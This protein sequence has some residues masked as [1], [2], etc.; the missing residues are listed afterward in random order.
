MEII[1][2]PSPNHNERPAGDAVSC[3]V[4]HYT[5]MQSG[6]AALQR[7]VDPA[8][9]V[10]AH[11]LIEEDGLIYRLVDEERRAWHAGRSLWGGRDDINSVSVGIELVNPGHQWGYRAFPPAQMQSFIRLAREIIGRHRILP[12]RILGHSDVA[13]DRKEDPGELFDWAWCAGQGVGLWP[14]PA[15]GAGPILGPGSSGDTVTALQ[16]DLAAFG[17]G[18]PVTGSFDDMTRLVAIAFQRHFHPQRLDGC[19]DAACRAKLDWLID[20]I[21]A[22]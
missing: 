18:C 16:R 8:A 15:V 3:L 4:V 21:R 13:P 10:S 1:E 7:L 22:G 17:Y 2:S 19:F 5:G 9:A 14:E 20:R 12:E 11:Y 6:A